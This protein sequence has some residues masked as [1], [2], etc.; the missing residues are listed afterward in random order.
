MRLVRL[1]Q[2]PFQLTGFLPEFSW[3]YS[4]A[5]SR[6]AAVHREASSNRMLKKSFL[7]FF[8]HD[9]P[10]MNSAKSYKLLFKCW[11]A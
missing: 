3:V 8:S 1:M 6:L 10:E 9:L 11:R 4:Q 5:V 7:D 2:Y